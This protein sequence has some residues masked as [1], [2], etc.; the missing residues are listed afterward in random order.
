[1]KS[2]LTG[3]EVEAQPAKVS[4]RHKLPGAVLELLETR[5]ELATELDQVLRES[6]CREA[7]AQTANITGNQSTTTQTAGQG[8]TIN[9]GRG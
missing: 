7:V 5:P 1:M 9:I 6:G 3:A 2:K 4:V 8:N